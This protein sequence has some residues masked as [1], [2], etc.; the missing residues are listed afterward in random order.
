MSRFSRL[1]LQIGKDNL[2]KLS[3]THIAIVGIG[4]V[5]GAT[6]EALARSGIGEF[7]IIDGDKVEETNINR[8]LIA[9]NS[10][11]GEYKVDA[12][13]KRI[14]D[15][16]PEVIVHTYPLFID[17]EHQ[18]DLKNIDY[19]IDT[20]DTVKAK[21]ALISYAKTNNIKVISAMGA[22]NK[23]N[24]M[25]FVITDISKTEGDPLAKRIRQELKS[26]NIKDVKVCF[27]KE[28]PIYKG[29][30]ISSNSFTPLA[31]GILIAK[32]VFS[33]LIAK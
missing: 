2:D 5:G 22:G 12:F 11:I 13:K 8:Q 9:L 14:L 16:N 10:T 1:E 19:I 27:S 28:T 31:C 4:G 18:F 29:T 21:I 25:G 20:C 6:L 24:P 17:E 15:I 3:K 26:L 7:S 32:E 23:L 30:T 33:D